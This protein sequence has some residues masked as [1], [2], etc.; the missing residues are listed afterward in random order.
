MMLLICTMSFVLRLL[1]IV[2]VACAKNQRDS[3]QEDPEPVTYYVSVISA[4]LPGPR[5]MDSRVDYFNS[6]VQR[7]HNNVGN[8]SGSNDGVVLAAIPSGIPLRRGRRRLL[9][10]GKNEMTP[11]AEERPKLLQRHLGSTALCLLVACLVLM[12]LLLCLAIAAL[13]LRARYRARDKTLYATLSASDPDLPTPATSSTRG[14]WHL[15]GEGP[16]TNTAV[17][18]ARWSRKVTKNSTS[19]PAFRSTKAKRASSLGKRQASR[20][21]T[22]G[23]QPSAMLTES[24]EAKA[25]PSPAV[26]NAAECLTPL[27]LEGVFAGSAE[28]RKLF[29]VKSNEALL[30]LRSYSVV[31]TDTAD[32]QRASVHR[33]DRDESGKQRSR[34]G[35]SRKRRK[36]R[37]DPSGHCNAVLGSH[38]ADS[39]AD[40]SVP[41]SATSTFKGVDL[42]EDYHQYSYSDDVRLA[43]GASPVPLPTIIQRSVTK[44]IR[45]WRTRGS[46]AVSSLW[47]SSS[48][49]PSVGVGRE[50]VPL[51]LSARRGR[52]QQLGSQT[53]A[54]TKP[55]ENCIYTMTDATPWT[56]LLALCTEPKPVEFQQVIQ[57]NSKA[58]LVRCN[59][60]DGD[61]FC[62]GASP[63]EERLVRVLRLRP[64]DVR[65][66]TARLRLAR[67]LCS[68]KD[69]AQNRTSAFFLDARTTLVRDT[70][71]KL[72]WDARQ[73]NREGPAAGDTSPEDLK[74]PAHYLVTE[75]QSGWRPL[76]SCELPGPVQ[77]ESVLEQAC[78]A[79]AVAESALDFEHRLPVVGAVL[80]RP[81]RSPRVEFT[82]RGRLERIASAGFKI[83]LQG[84]QMARMTIDGRPEYTELSRHREFV[85]G[86]EESR[87]C[88]KMAS[89]LSNQAARFKPLTNVLWLQH[90]AA[91][92]SRQS[93]ET[94]AA[95]APWV[96]VLAVA[97]SAQDAA[98][99]AADVTANVTAGRRPVHLLRRRRKQ[100]NKNAPRPADKSGGTDHP[101]APSRQRPSSATDDVA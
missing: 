24:S 57:N 86:E 98:E 62:L 39:D 3:S 82:L 44:T 99:E 36:R 6:S 89:R 40:A 100:P 55:E 54:I 43:P 90:L 101:S 4:D 16:L 23:G 38:N 45:R 29:R 42:S 78:W 75:I 80:V 27:S 66:H 68:L 34:S 85:V 12:A 97:T 52:L 9:T 73:R 7:R 58:A 18:T 64:Q 47:T 35:G 53:I 91:W 77:A 14:R 72:L 46:A 84:L 11:S 56:Q 65:W 51:P 5:P 70:Y 60:G 26:T 93:A 33:S 8:L 61:L 10:Y 95:L 87:V 31:R 21:S 83:R 28:G 74:Q 2:S 69:N 81:T 41:T 49:E 79:L 19:A 96:G 88:E 15:S 37:V 76:T 13:W 94:E 25:T 17:G 20:S 92:L 1:C 32:R 59:D 48:A 30:P 71:P 63:A 22:D 67:E 50:A